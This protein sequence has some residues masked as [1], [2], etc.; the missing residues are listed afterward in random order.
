MAALIPRSGR[1]A[2]PLDELLVDDVV[3]REYRAAL[4]GRR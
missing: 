4:V 2:A 1:V 3:I